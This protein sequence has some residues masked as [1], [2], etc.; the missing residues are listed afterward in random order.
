MK[1]GPLPFDKKNCLINRIELKKNFDGG[2]IFSILCSKEIEFKIEF[3][4]IFGNGKT[5][6]ILNET[7]FNRIWI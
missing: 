2:S 4:S 6:V 1:N 3:K 7:K 5:I